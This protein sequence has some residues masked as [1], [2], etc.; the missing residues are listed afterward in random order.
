MSKSNGPPAEAQTTAQKPSVVDPSTHH[1]SCWVVIPAI[2]ALL[3]A[4]YLAGIPPLPSGYYALC[5]PRGM[6]YTVDSH[7]GCTMQRAHYVVKAQHAS[8]R[9][10]ILKN[11]GRY[12]AFTLFETDVPRLRLTE[13]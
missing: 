1:S 3:L 10:T 13:R 6:I 2:C 5:S 11:L 12:S 7:R 9:M 4:M 8:K